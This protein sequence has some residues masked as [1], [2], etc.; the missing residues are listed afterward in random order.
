MPYPSVFRR[1]KTGNYRVSPFKVHKRWL[2]TS[3]SFSSSGTAVH[4]GAH[5]KEI[6]PIGTTTLTT[7][8]QND[9]T[10]GTILSIG[11]KAAND[12]RNTNWD[13][14][15]QNIIWHSIDHKYYQHPYDP[16]KNLGASNRR[17]IKKSLFISASS[18]TMPYFRCGESIKKGSV[19]ITDSVNHHVY[20]GSRDS[21]A[22]SATD[23]G[24]TLY[25]DGYG[26][27]RD[28]LINSQSFATAS[29]LVAY[30]GFNDEYRHF[31]MNTGTHSKPIKFESNVYE[32]DV[33]SIAKNIKIDRGIKMDGFTD[34]LN[35]T[36]SREVLTNGNFTSWTNYT[37]S[38]QYPTGWS[39]PSS[40]LAAIFTSATTQSLVKSGSDA[41]N[42]YYT[43]SGST[44]ANILIFSQ[45]GTTSQSLHK[46][47]FISQSNVL[48]P[49][50]YYYYRHL[51]H[52]ASAS[53]FTGQTN[54]PFTVRVP[55]SS[56]QDQIITEHDRTLGGSIGTQLY[57]HYDPV[58]GVQSAIFR[59][60]G[61]DLIISQ[62]LD[63]KP[64]D[65]NNTGISAETGFSNVQ[66]REIIQPRSGLQA[67]FTGTSY[68]KTPAIKPI[69]F[70]K[71]DDFAISFWYGGNPSQST[72][73]LP[74]PHQYATGSV[75]F[76][77]NP[78]GSAYRTGSYYFIW[79]YG[80]NSS[81][82]TGSACL[83]MSGSTL[84]PHVRFVMKG[85]NELANFPDVPAG[86][87]AGIPTYYFASAST[88]TATMANLV[89]KMN[90][91][92]TGSKP[93]PITASHDASTVGRVYYWGTSPGGELNL[94]QVYTSSHWS[95]S[96]HGGPTGSPT[97]GGVSHKSVVRQSIQS[98]AGLADSVKIGDYYFTFVS[99]SYGEY[100]QNGQ[101][102][103]TGGKSVFIHVSQSWNNMINTLEPARGLRD[104]INNSASLHGMSGISASTTMNGNIA[105]VHISSS[106]PIDSFT[107]IPILTASI[108]IIGSSGSQDTK[109][110]IT[111]TE[112]STANSQTSGAF[113]FTD[114]EGRS[115]YSTNQIVSSLKGHV[116]AGALMKN[117]IISKRGVQ[118]TI[119]YSKKTNKRL[120]VEENVTKN[121]YPFDISVYNQ[122]AGTELNGKLVFGV[123]SGTKIFESASATFF[124]GSEHHVVAQKSGS[125]Y[126]L[127]VNGTREWQA[128]YTSKTDVKN[129]SKLM[130]GSTNTAFSQS[131]SGSLDEV[132][133]YNQPLNETA[134][135]SLANTHYLSAS[136]YQTSVAG[137]VFY[138]TGQSIIS[139]VLP[140][141][142]N[143]LGDGGNIISGSNPWVVRYQ[144][145]HTIWENEVLVEVP[146]GTFNVTMNP[147]ALAKANTDRL[148]HAF[149]GSLT[150]YITTIGLYNDNAQLLAIG[151]L[152]QPIIKRSDVDMNF[153][154]RWD[155]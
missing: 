55:N 87:N 74:V 154:V 2:V 90:D 28:P 136:C 10:A 77:H 102:S 110:R 88:Q 23:S 38:Y 63:V 43:I 45:S 117:S 114:I 84:Y 49:G 54:A 112:M 132:R 91:Q 13:D 64:L 30:W 48:T 115:R 78:S 60:S 140:K 124:T 153:I 12:P 105:T 51:L 27:L 69:N 79:Q 97:N 33:H 5:R 144:G 106:T 56:G 11:T 113:S 47:V 7:F 131:L 52:Y 18:I 118:D 67:R 19:R 101:G 85:A 135:K 147:T 6:T 125:V 98:A 76:N 42:N 92:S 66:C 41:Q 96:V 138:K 80:G 29:N 103:A 58:R 95:G 14:S 61:T 59:A 93:L 145:T 151:K 50:K 89:K 104:A 150:P 20:T 146:A 21:G 40:S 15:Y 94:I 32:T 73:P 68:I 57:G 22:G 116:G 36:S 142:F 82:P 130:F 3:S 99:A 149:T 83:T 128:T 8:G 152:A 100:Y 137:N 81:L 129:L 134:I 122:N 46:G 111:H 37:G 35:A 26:N 120:V 143:A 148:K 127:W 31:K 139:S 39:N 126:E 108:N 9:Y 70:D 155:Y 24:F 53:M 1:I 119:R 109:R 17:T 16:A 121:R 86:N 34:L 123:S 4:L 25:D 133:I 75:R 65:K 71:E 107:S 62:S 141:H 44:G 72:A